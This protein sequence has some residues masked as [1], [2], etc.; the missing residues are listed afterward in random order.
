[1]RKLVRARWPVLLEFCA[2]VVCMVHAGCRQEPD[3]DG[4]TDQSTADS[5][6]VVQPSDARLLLRQGVAALENKD[7]QAAEQSLS[8]LVRFLPRS[9]TALRNLAILRTLMIVDSESTFRRG[10]TDSERR[11]FATA[12][13]VAE[14]AISAYR[15]GVDQS[16]DQV[17]ADLLQG[18]LLTFSTQPNERAYT[19]GVQLLQHAAELQPDRAD[20]QI[21]LAEALSRGTASRDSLSVLEHLLE[22]CR[23]A[24]ENLHALRLLLQQQAALLRSTDADVKQ[25]ALDTVPATLTAARHLIRSLNDMIRRHARVDLVSVID[26]A[27]QDSNA[28]AESFIVPALTIANTIKAEIAVQIDQRRLDRDPLDYVLT[29]FS[30]GQF[31]ED[32]ALGGTPETSVLT[33]FQLSRLLPEVEAITD[34]AVADMTLDGRLNLTVVRDGRVEVYAR[35]AESPDDWTIEISVPDEPSQWQSVLPADFDR[36]FE[37]SSRTGSVVLED[38]DVDR[39]VRRSSAEKP[40]F[41]TDL[42]VVVWNT[43]QLAILQNNLDSDGDRLLRPIEIFDI[44]QISDVDV[45]DVDADGDLD[46]LVG[47]RQGI[48]LLT[49]TTGMQFLSRQVTT[50]A[51]TQLVTGDVDRNVAVDAVGVSETGQSGLL[52]NLFHGRFRWLPAGDIFGTTAAGAAVEL[53]D[54]DTN[55]SWDVL[56]GGSAG[57][58]LHR[59]RTT[60]PGNLIPLNESAVTTSSVTDFVVADLDNDGRQDIAALVESGCRLWRGMP[61]GTFSQLDVEMPTVSGRQI[62]QA[63]VDDDGDLDLLIVDDA[64]RLILLDNSDGNRNRW[65]KLVV[66]GKEDDDQFRSLRVNMHGIGTVLEAASGDSLQTQIVTEP[67]VHLGLGQADQLQGLRLIWPNG[68]PQHIVT[69]EHLQAR[70]VV[71]APQILKGSCPYIYTWNGSEFEFFSDCLWASPI[72]LV[73]ANGDLAPTREWEHL[74][75]PERHLRP[76]GDEYVLQ[77]T[78]ELWEIAYFDQVELIAVDHPADVQIFTNEKVGPPSLAAH[79][80]HTVRHPRLPKSVTDGNGND[81]LPG[82]SDMDGDYVQPFTKR[83]LQGLTDEWTMEFDAGEIPSDADLRLFLT[84]WIFP[85]DTSIN[86]QIQQNANLQPPAPPVVEVPVE[87]GNW[88]IVR[89]F[90]GFPSGKTK[91]MVVDLTGVLNSDNSRFRLRSTMELY[92]DSAFLTVSESDEPTVSHPCPLVGGDLH[93]RGFS[94]RDYEGSVFRDGNGPEGY[95]YAQVHTARRWPTIAGRFTQFGE[96]GDLIQKHDDQLV[97]MGPGD[98]LTLRFAAPTEAIPKGWV[99]DFVLRNVGWDKDADLNTVYGQTSE[100]YPFRAMTHY[101]FATTDEEPASSAYEQYLNAFQTRQ[102]SPFP[103]WK[104]SAPKS[105]SNPRLN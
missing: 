74:L 46:I 103:F 57:I 26:E 85:T 93:H 52:Q 86:L 7:W 60:S 43:S 89:P 10:G 56:V 33:D 47:S 77:L 30:P 22:A 71:L 37:R 3:S 95:N 79:R 39:S 23:L 14:A 45:T 58:T 6:G 67:V 25:R 44:P 34:V 9:R 91:T 28:S 82:L 41:D 35:D 84:G 76:R 73:Q 83:R 65:M 105:S 75:I 16:D 101:P 97:V 96:V 80:I 55:Q 88:Q 4:A 11:Q 63:D 27:L 59:T 21:V 20:V 29:R 15:D 99:R 70:C 38:A 90:I 94:R 61:D 68:V 8:R 18:K 98:E 72:G 53:V 17:L 19:Q 32:Q 50:Q 49:N 51:V 31:P 78:E 62:K 64:G 42:D 36:D 2:A 87:D 5:S 48:W 12:I 104:W 81:L 69:P 100:P 66:R 1:M 40:R 13:E 54:S 102:Y 92:F 24:P